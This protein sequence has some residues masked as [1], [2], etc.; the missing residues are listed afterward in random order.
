MK[1]TTTTASTTKTATDNN[2]Y[3]NNNV[4]E[5][6][7]LKYFNN[8]NSILKKNLIECIGSLAYGRSF[9]LNMEGGVVEVVSH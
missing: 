5:L 8:F 1:V 9:G 6:G 3:N 4:F 7:K 2:N